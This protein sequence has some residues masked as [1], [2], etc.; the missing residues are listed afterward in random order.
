MDEWPELSRSRD[1]TRAKIL[2]PSAGRANWRENPPW[3]FVLPTTPSGFLSPSKPS[4][5]VSSSKSS[6]LARRR[7]RSWSS[8][9]YV[10]EPVTVICPL[11]ARGGAVAPSVAALGPLASLRSP[12][13]DTKRYWHCTPPAGRGSTTHP[14]RASA[15]RIAANGTPAQLR[16][17][18]NSSGA[19]SGGFHRSEG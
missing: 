3:S 4:K 6:T 13:E 10:K 5:D 17:T 18:A 1:D 8:K 11:S 2:V 15:W 16:S 9:R 19:C 7:G 14:A 12:R